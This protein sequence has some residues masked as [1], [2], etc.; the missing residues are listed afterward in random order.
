M[1][2]N[3]FSTSFYAY[4]YLSASPACYITAYLYKLPGAVYI[5]CCPE[6]PQNDISEG[7]AFC[8]TWVDKF[9]R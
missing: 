4:L 1:V 8:N 7:E 5:F 6:I 3:F 9:Q 2:T